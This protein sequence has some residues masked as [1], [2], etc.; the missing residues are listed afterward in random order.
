[1]NTNKPWHRLHQE[2]D[3]A[4]GAFTIYRDMGCVRSLAKTAKA[5]GKKKHY[6]SQ[7]EKW[8]KRYEWVRRS[9]IY[10]EYLDHQKLILAEG[11]LIE[12]H[13]FALDNGKK[14]IE[15][16]V[17]ISCGERWCEPHNL[18][19]IE[20]YLETIGLKKKEYK[21]DVSSQIDRQK[22]DKSRALLDT[23]KSGSGNF[24]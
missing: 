14:I 24:N 6:T 10:D 12:L 15:E 1:M 17:Q 4:F 9:L 7:L 23:L 13:N 21:E 3:I 22:W 5:L 16:L 18:K 11:R 20:M 2:S 8:S 19:A